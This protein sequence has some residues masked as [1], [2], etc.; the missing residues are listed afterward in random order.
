MELLPGTTRVAASPP[1]WSAA[2]PLWFLIPLSMIWPVCWWTLLRRN[3]LRITRQNQGLCTNCGYDLR[4][5]PDRCP[6]C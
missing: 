1:E 3:R 4:S 6:E 2:V 5:T